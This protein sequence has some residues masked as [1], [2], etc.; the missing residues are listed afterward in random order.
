MNHYA[1]C[2]DLHLDHLGDNDAALID[3]AQRLVA[4]EPQGV[5]ITGDIS[6]ANKL[7]Y[8]LSVIERVVQRP[9]YYTLGNHDYYGSDIETVRKQMKEISNM[10]QYL[11]YMPT[12]QYLAL[13]PVT[14]LVGHDG[15]YDAMLGDAK[16]S[17][18]MMSDWSMIRDFV[19]HSGGRRGLQTGL[20]FN[21][22]AVIKQAQALAMEGVLHVQA[23]IKSAVR[24]HRSVIVLT[25]FPPFAEAHIYQGA[26][27]NA[28]AM[29]WYT[30][31]LMGNMLL[32]AAKVYPNVN[33]T[34]L[35]GHTHG[36]ATFQAARN[37]I[38]RVGAAEYGHPELQSLVE[39]A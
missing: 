7:I 38:C 30:S 22:G 2:T 27:G 19:Q 13:T 18:F 34:V 8:H 32:D 1:W 25:H 4:N 5:M 9:V 39:V 17:R 20:G 21:R 15:W 6:N 36:A 3:F 31:K 37:L 10:S 33:F 26:V 24:Y 23:S 28:E 29:P 14:A 35:C 11:K 12:M 16:G